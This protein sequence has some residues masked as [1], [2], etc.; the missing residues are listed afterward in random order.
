[1]AFKLAKIRKAI[2]DAEGTKKIIVILLACAFTAFALTAGS[3]LLIRTFSDAKSAEPS[4]E[5][6]FAVSE[7]QMQTQIAD[8][9]KKMNTL[10]NLVSQL[11]SQVK[12]STVPAS[13]APVQPPSTELAVVSANL[14][15]LS[16]SVASLQTQVKTLEDNYK[17][18]STII[19]TSAVVVNG[20][21][22]TF[23]SNN[24]YVPSTGTTPPGI[25]QFAIKIGNLSGSAISNLDI[26]GIISSTQSFTNM[27]ATGYPQ[28]VD[29]SGLCNYVFYISPN[30]T[31]N[32][33]AYGAKSSLS[34][35]VNGSI[36][37]RPKFTVVASAG[38]RLPASVY[39]VA[40]NTITFDKAAK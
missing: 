18:N 29:A 25:A 20:L 37:L 12:T 8:I 10:N 24:I 22:I 34:I 40:L 9:S 11:Q 32:F 7:K 16:S 35:P 4:P 15:K 2:F 33:E 19:G 31:L 30:N 13:P 28:L 38:N 26:I 3:L 36:I 6:T 23:V 14:N 39:T 1:L 17:A 27:V 21:S 5:A